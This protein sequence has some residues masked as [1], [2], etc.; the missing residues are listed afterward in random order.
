VADNRPRAKRIRHA[1][2]AALVY[3]LFQL[4]RLL[5]F[6]VASGIGGRIGR[7]IG[8]LLPPTGVAR[9]NLAAAF[10]EKN[11]GEIE[12]IIQGMW[13]NLGRVAAEYPHMLALR[14]YQPE[15]PVE[16]VG[17]EIVDRLAADGKPAVLF[18][19]HIANWEV[20]RACLIQRGLDIVAVY[21]AANNPWIDRLILEGRNDLKGGL[22][23][24]GSTGARASLAAMKQGQHLCVL[25]DQKMNDGIAAPFFGRPAMT[26]SAPIELARR[27]D[28]PLV[29]VRAERLDGARF[30]VTIMEPVER[31]P[32]DNRHDAVR[33]GVQRMNQVLESWIRDR[34]EQ[35]LWV[36][37]RWQD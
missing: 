17:A 21:R 25:V 22:F 11:A 15:S 36:H 20:T 2:E 31:E 23:P 30:R 3:P 10:P 7:L 33:S 14:I 4:F 13:E 8:P 37:N 16:V 6:P 1:L 34:P 12:R 18:T 32:S 9:R 19:G 5:P 28:C 26:V 27:F 29:P 24:K 35:W